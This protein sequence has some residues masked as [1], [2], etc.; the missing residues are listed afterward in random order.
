VGEDLRSSAGGQECRRLRIFVSSPTD[1]PD[2]RL[3]ADLIVDK[4]SQ[5]YSRFF[6]IESYRWEHENVTFCPAVSSG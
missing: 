5:D 2:E 4:L 1:V 3:R 6:T